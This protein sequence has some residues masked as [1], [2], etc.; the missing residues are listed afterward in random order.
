MTTMRSFGAAAAV[1]LLPM[2]AAAGVPST[3]NAQ[4]DMNGNG[5]LDA[6]EIQLGLIHK[7]SRLNLPGLRRL[8]PKER[9]E[10]IAA[11]IKAAEFQK[12]ESDSAAELA[13]LQKEYALESQNPPYSL[14]R[15]DPKA[16]GLRHILVEGQTV[17]EAANQPQATRWSAALRRTR[18]GALKALRDPSS[19]I[20]DPFKEG[21]LF[22]YRRDENA[23]VDTINASGTFGLSWHL[24]PNPSYDAAFLPKGHDRPVGATVDNMRPLR[25][26]E[27]FFLTTI[28]RSDNNKAIPKTEANHPASNPAEKDTLEFEFGLTNQYAWPQRI[29]EGATD[30]SEI[31]RFGDNWLGLSAL[32]VTGALKCTTDSEF[33]RNIWSGALTLNPVWALPGMEAWHSPFHYTNRYGRECSYFAFRYSLNTE[34]IGGTVEEENSS[35]FQRAED[36]FFYAGFNA[37]IEVRPFPDLLDQRLTLLASYSQYEGLFEGTEGTQEFRASLRYYIPFAFGLPRRFPAKGVK[38]S[39]FVYEPGQLMWALQIEYR[40]GQTPITLEDEQ[41]LTFGVSL[42]F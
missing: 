25:N 12:E 29:P 18:D 4:L 38:G 14:D 10:A 1:L 15:I 2:A 9:K 34:L 27:I 17:E 7:K 20:Q 16:F 11:V 8:P 31:S 28:D 5:K 40:N 13:Q 3:L 41:S 22:S 6:D 37:S 39:D 42:A 23:G 19:D 33:R 36:G 30:P 21:A 26:S 35:D 32:G 24:G